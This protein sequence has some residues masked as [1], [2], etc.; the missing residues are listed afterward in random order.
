MHDLDLDA[1]LSR[2]E[3]P[4][5]RWKVGAI[6]EDVRALVEEVRRLRA[7]RALLTEAERG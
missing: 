4:Y 5:A 6:R 3:T 2:A 1:I 7:E